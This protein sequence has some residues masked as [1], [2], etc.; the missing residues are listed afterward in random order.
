[1]PL[2]AHV[3]QQ[4]RWRR[5]TLGFSLAQLAEQLGVTYQQL[6]KYEQGRNRLD[7]GML[8]QLSRAL[9]MPIAGFFESYAAADPAATPAQRGEP[10]AEPDERAARLVAAW[11]TVPQDVASKVLNLLCAVA[12]M[13]GARRTDPT[14]GV[15]EA[16]APFLSGAAMRAEAAAAAVSAYLFL[17]LDDSACDRVAEA[18]AAVPEIRRCDSLIGDIDMI[19]LI[20]A[21]DIAGIDRI[22]LAVEA[23]DGVARVSTRIV[24][25]QRFDRKP[26]GGLPD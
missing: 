11:Q 22:R 3:G 12:A 13:A 4:V 15:A 20:G 21:E 14:G 6:Q 19:L 18:L 17:T 26:D 10:V 23:I 25:A 9:D 24:L 8:Y 7:I 1:M 5:K 16:A 2:Y